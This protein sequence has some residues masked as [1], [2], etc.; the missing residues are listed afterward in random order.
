MVS[1]SEGHE[2]PN[3]VGHQTPRC[4]MLGSHLAGLSI[5]RQNLLGEPQLVKLNCRLVPL[6]DQNLPLGVKGLDPGFHLVFLFW[7][8]FC[9][10][11]AKK[12]LLRWD[13]CPGW[14]DSLSWPTGGPSLWC[15]GSFFWAL[16]LDLSAS[17]PSW[18]VGS[19]LC[20]V[21]YVLESHRFWH[22]ILWGL[23][24]PSC[25]LQRVLS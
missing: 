16:N 7:T 15:T 17:A 4:E 13:C 2:M 3:L 14:N 19:I 6:A 5:A 10:A 23:V 11:E 1:L 8:P 22:Q 9:L 20:E 18:S 21:N 25:V 12:L 24:Q